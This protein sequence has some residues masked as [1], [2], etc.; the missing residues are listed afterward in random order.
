MGEGEGLVKAV[1]RRERGKCSVERGIE[2][3]QGRKGL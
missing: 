3:G 1:D 2:E